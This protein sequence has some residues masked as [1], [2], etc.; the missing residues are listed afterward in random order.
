MDVLVL[1]AVFFI[2]LFLEVP[3]AFKLCL[4]A[5][6]Y[7]IGFVDVRLIIIAQKKI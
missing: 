4:S 6:F 7:M 5:L 3:I 2:L 1:M